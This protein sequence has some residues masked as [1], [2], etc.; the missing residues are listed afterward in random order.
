MKTILDGRVT[1]LNGPIQ[2]LSW[3]YE[4]NVPS[5]RVRS[6]EGEGAARRRRME[7]SA[8]TGVRAK[9]GKPLAFTL[10]TQA[11]FAIRENVAQAIQKQLKDVGV[12]MKVQLDRRNVDQ[13]RLVQRR[14]RRDAALV[15]IGRRS[16]D[17]AVLRRRS[18]AAGRPQHQLSQR[19]RADEAPLRVGSNGRSSEAKRAAA[20]T[21][22]AASPSSC[23]RSRSTTRRR[24]TR[25]RRR[26]RTSR[27][28]RRTP[29]R[30][31]TCTSGR[32]LQR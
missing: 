30:S 2:P 7:A 10:I 8:P 14:L 21:R 23:R 19:R 18:H 31:G 12:D 13:R 16:G 24:S 1:T 27:A 17:H 29:A 15:A 5:Y 11:G 22:N 32:C 9:D 25:C 20:A 4:P 6:G 28:I 26:S 3:A